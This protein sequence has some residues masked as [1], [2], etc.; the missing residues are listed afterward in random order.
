MEFGGVEFVEDLV[1]ETVWFGV[2]VVFFIEMDEDDIDKED[3]GKLVE[4]VPTVFVLFRGFG[5]EYGGETCAIA[6]AYFEGGCTLYPGKG[7][8]SGFVLL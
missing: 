1:S 3:A 7:G 5:L 4:P 8:L 2:G 6:F